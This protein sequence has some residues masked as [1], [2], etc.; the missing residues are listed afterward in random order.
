MAAADERAPLALGA[1]VALELVVVVHGWLR[2]L[3][4]ELAL[5]LAISR[6]S[7]RRIESAVS[8]IEDLL[9]ECRHALTLLAF[10]GARNT[11]ACREVAV[12]RCGE[13]LATWEAA[14]KE[15]EARKADRARA[16]FERFTRTLGYAL[17][18]IVGHLAPRQPGDA[19][20]ERRRE[21]EER[22]LTRRD[23]PVM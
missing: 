15:A 22:M 9:A 14:M 20:E 23:L 1:S 5:D 6:P 16:T 2:D 8:E 3:R 19:R 21:E 17:E 4:T 10:E 7:V 18:K 11:E 12:E 13:I